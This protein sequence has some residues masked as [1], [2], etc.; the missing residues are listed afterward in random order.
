MPNNKYDIYE[1]IFKFVV[2]V[3]KLVRLIPKTEENV[4]IIRQILG[5]I[6]GSRWSFY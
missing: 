2:N 4:V 5:A 1:R 6:A 3:I